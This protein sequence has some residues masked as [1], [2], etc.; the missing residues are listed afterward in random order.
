MA[1]ASRKD[2]TVPGPVLV[3]L[4]GHLVAVALLPVV[5]AGILDLVEIMRSQ[6]EDNTCLGTRHQLDLL[7]SG[8]RV[9]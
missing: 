7:K 6:M 3:A 1:V 9:V 5:L 8:T 4:V 2:L